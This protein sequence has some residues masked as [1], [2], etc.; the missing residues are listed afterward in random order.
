MISN[1]LKKAKVLSLFKEYVE[2]RG[3]CMDPAEPLL[4]RR[5][6]TLVYTSQSAAFEEAAHLAFEVHG[7]TVT[8]VKPPPQ[9]GGVAL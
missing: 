2:R 4:K 3:V 9:L 6:R 5:K 7:S 8:Q 1:E